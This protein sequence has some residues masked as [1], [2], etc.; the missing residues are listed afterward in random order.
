MTKGKGNGE[1]KLNI[2]QVHDHYR[3][4]GGEDQVVRNEGEL[5]REHGHNVYLYSRRNEEIPGMKVWEKVC[6]PFSAVF[7]LRTFYEVRKMIREKGIDLVHVHNTLPLISPSVFYAAFAAGVPVVMT[8]HNFRLLCP[9]GIFYRNGHVC[10]ECVQKG[11]WCGIKYGCYRGSRVQTLICALSIKVHRML[12]TYKKVHFICLTEFQKEKLL[13]LKQVDAE[14]VFVKPNFINWDGEIAAASERKNYVLYAGRL[15]ENKGIKVLLRTYKELA[16]G[17]LDDKEKIP[18]LIICGDGS[19]K[20]QCERYV[21]KHHLENVSLTGEV[22]NETVKKLMAEAKGIVVPSL[23]YE[24]FPMN[25]AEA[26]GVRTPVIGSDSGNVG[27]LIT[28]NVNGWKFETGNAKALAQVILDC[29]PQKCTF[30][31]PEAVLWTGE[32][33]YG[34]LIKI[35]ERCMGNVRKAKEK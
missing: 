30:K 17:N 35:Y 25:I 24:G 29:D 2:L 8:V 12:G 33:N 1:K 23:W 19:L 26:Y 6:L 16:K 11:L 28:D 14:K 3:I 18:K 9:N 4:A 34:K 32:G 21:K 13:Q 20:K 31:L 5:L 22:P 27:R 7:S 10:Q 15:E